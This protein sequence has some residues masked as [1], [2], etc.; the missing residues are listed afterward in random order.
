MELQ[1][2]LKRDVSVILRLASIGEMNAERNDDDFSDVK[3]QEY[4]KRALE[5]AAAGSHNVLMVG[6]PGSGKTMLS[7]RLLTILTPMTFEDAIETTKI[8]SVAGLLK[9]GQSLLAID[10]LGRLIIQYRMS[11]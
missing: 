7:K 9:S 1:G 4:A 5:F 11:H 6:P 3:G 8:H 10:L 2:I